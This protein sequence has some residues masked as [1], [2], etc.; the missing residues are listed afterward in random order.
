[1]NNNI[2]PKIHI[3]III[4]D[5]GM[6]GAQHMIYELAKNIDYSHYNVTIIC[7]EARRYSFLEQQII[8]ERYN[9]IFLKLNQYLKI[10]ELYYVLRKIKPDVVHVHQRGILAAFWAL[11]N[12]VYIITT[13]HTHPNAV[14]KWWLE[15][16]YFKLSL[17]LKRNIIVAIS[18]YNYDICKNYWHLPTKYISYINNGIDIPK[19]YNKP[20]NIFTFINVSRQDA[21][22]NQSLILK[23]LARLYMENTG[24]PIKLYLVGGGKRHELLKKQAK[25]LKIDHIV[26]FTGYIADPREYLAS[27]DVY[28]SSSHREGLSLSVLEAMASRLPIIATDAGGVRDLAQD[29]GILISDDDENGLFEAMKILRDNYELRIQKGNKSFEMVQNYSSVSMTNGYCSLYKTFSKNR[30]HRTHYCRPGR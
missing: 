14:F 2:K 29:N 20:H 30:N 5:V 18:K 27:S 19:Y 28:I 13:I 15:N 25:D 16:F 26:E 10:F 3:A 17:L 8:G 24:L 21:N 11:L 4:D 6:G 7:T 9:V 1:V 22:K 23:S 12:R